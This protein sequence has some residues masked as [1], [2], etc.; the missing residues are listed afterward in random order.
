MKKNIREIIKT[1]KTIYKEYKDKGMNSIYLWGSITNKDFN[2]D[3]SDIDS[4]AI[5]SNKLK[6]SEEA[7]IINEI[8]KLSPKIK[9]FKLRFVYL[10]ELNGKRRKGNLTKYITSE[11]LLYEMGY[12]VYVCGIKYSNKDFNLKPNL[13]NIIRGL[14]KIIKKR[15][16]NIKDNKYIEKAVLR[17]IYYEEQLKGN[18]FQYSKKDLMKKA[19]GK[20]KLLVK[21]ILK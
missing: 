3:K 2:P 20:N 9:D 8:K 11:Q 4:I 6:L 16:K 18:K 21:D 17:L 19:T 12:W 5:C 10:D 13:K 15:S 1:L 7:K 14:Q